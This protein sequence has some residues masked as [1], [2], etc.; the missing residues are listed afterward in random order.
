MK[1]FIARHSLFV[2]GQRSG[3]SR[4]SPL[5]SHLC[6]ISYFL[7]LTSCI[8]HLASCFSNLPAQDDPGQDLELLQKENAVSEKIRHQ[9]ESLL[10]KYYEKESFVVNVKTSLERI[11]IKDKT[12]KAKKE[13]A[14]DYELPGLPFPLQK[15]SARSPQIEQIIAEQ[16]I[17]TDK[18]KVANTEVIV[19]LDEKKYT[20]DDEIFIRTVIETSAGIN[21]LRGDTILIKRLAFPPPVDIRKV[22]KEQT[23]P[24]SPVK[25][26]WRKEVYPYIY[27]GSII[28]LLLFFVVILLQVINLVRSTVANRK[29]AFALPPMD[30]QQKS[31]AP[32]VSAVAKPVALPSVG[33]EK[34]SGERKDL[35]YELRQLMVATLVGNPELSCEIFNRWIGEGDSGI[36][37]VASFLKASDPK[38]LEVI[39]DYLNRDV[40][41]KIDFAMNQIVSMEQEDII[42]IF[43]RF[44]EEFQK[45]QSIKASKE[46]S[47]TDL[48]RFLKELEP[49]QVFHIIKDEAP[50]II[51]IVLAQ[52]SAET[53]NT[54]LSD[55]P[56][57][58][59][60]E[61]IL[62]MGKLKKI[63]VTVY[64]DIADKLTK[65][66]LQ[67][68]SL[69]Y[70]TTDGVE[71]LVKLL[72]ASAPDVE[73]QILKSV[74]QQNI[75][76]VQEIRKVYV[77]FDELTL[78]PDKVLADI[79]RG[80]DREI[81]TNALIGAG[82]EIKNKIITNLPTRM[83]IIVSDTL[84]SLE[85]EGGVPTEEI[86]N[87]RKNITKRIR[88]LARSGKLDLKKY[89]T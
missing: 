70:V 2:G 39:S 61:I 41:G 75:A 85:E 59:R 33:Q 17:F 20:R 79:L 74:S 30:I 56:P 10:G 28:L 63:P 9:I 76:L 37:Q 48:F 27:Y 26:D 77:T 18:F 43:K 6:F 88:E 54:V 36:Y 50:G 14:V 29:P 51:G 19:I 1:H 7:L 38:L 84:K 82:A 89:L 57:D 68:E 49:H 65:K 83:K 5:I 46:S 64:K 35:F 3:V 31:I 80:V 73:Q 60:D 72:E 13:E 4:L 69:K 25:D 45:E 47:S 86:Y 32:P 16:L 44:R 78:L 11:K 23:E 34:S 8:L 53:A 71:A 81:I 22:V 87:A 24:P 15:E 42:E 67:V 66:A 55:I 12:P 62:E 40:V 21:E 58:R 52:L